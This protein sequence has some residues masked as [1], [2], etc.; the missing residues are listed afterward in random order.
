MDKSDPN[1]VQS[2][3]DQKAYS[4]TFAQQDFVKKNYQT[5]GLLELARKTYKEDGLDERTV[6]YDQMRR[7]VAKIKNNVLPVQFTEDQLTFIENNSHAMKPIEL[8][9]NLF[10]D[11][12]IVP[13]SRE[14]QT[15]AEYLKAVG[16]GE[17]GEA[18]MDDYRPPKAAASLIR[19]INAAAPQANWD[20]NDLTVFQKKCVE[21][22][23]SYMASAR[24]SSFM[25][26]IPEPEMKA[27]FEEE[28]VKAVYD[29]HDLNT[30]ELNMFISLC[31]E[32]VNIQQQTRAKMAL[33]QKIS[34][35]IEN[36]DDKRLYMTW[37]DLLGARENEI[38]RSKSRAKDLQ[39]ALSSTRSKRLESQAMVNE[40]LSKFV[41]EWKSE[42]GRLRAI[43]ISEAKAMELEKEI[44]RIESAEDYIANVMG[45]GKDEILSF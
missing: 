40:S 45:I 29:K 11:K 24:V 44:D 33:E 14:T 37:V 41:E 18:A 23:R 19:K 16:V 36:D 28:F 26:I 43:I 25:R 1:Y 7:Y 22:L 39:V 4:L 15:I 31:S 17:G 10:P 27:L 20:A 5:L 9:K 2:V 6:E 35:T 12:K 8:A 42:E 21:S 34:G 38:H 3:I 13:L 32:Y 30:E